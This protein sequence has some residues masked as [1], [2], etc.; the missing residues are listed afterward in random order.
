MTLIKVLKL[1]HLNKTS[2]I[3]NQYKYRLPVTPYLY[4]LISQVS[5]LS[6]M[7]LEVFGAF[8]TVKL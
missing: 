7:F 6:G 4:L 2:K 8:M 5:L 3:L 1:H